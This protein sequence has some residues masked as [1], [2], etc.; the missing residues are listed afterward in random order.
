M[1]GKRKRFAFPVLGLLLLSACTILQ[2]YESQLPPLDSGSADFSNYVAL[3]AAI[4]AGYHSGALY[5]SAQYYSFP[6]ILSRSMRTEGFRQPRIN[7]PGWSSPMPGEGHL[8]IRFDDA[9]VPTME[10]LPWPEGWETNTDLWPGPLDLLDPL[11]HQNLSI[12]LATVQ[13]LLNTR[14]PFDA[15]GQLNP[16]YNFILRNGIEECGWFPQILSAWEQAVLLNPTFLTLSAG[17]S[18]VLTP[19]LFGTGVPLASGPEFESS[20]SQLLDSLESHLPDCDLLLL[21]VPSVLDFAFFRSVPPR[22]IGHDLEELTLPGGGG[23]P[24]HGE[25]GVLLEEDLVLLEA[26]FDVLDG[27]GLPRDEMIQYFM[28]TEA[29]EEASAAAM[30]DS[31]YPRNGELLSENLVLRESEWTQLADRVIDYNQSIAALAEARGHC[32]VDFY[33]LFQRVLD[34]SASFNGHEMSAEFL[35]NFFSL[36]GIHPTR[37]GNALIVDEITSVINE[38]FHS[39]LQVPLLEDLP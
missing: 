5:E 16:Y 34:G 18:E 15:Q 22:A 20:Y 33:S 13:D 39:N 2:P 3:G 14:G 23:I 8:V 30:L 9:G 4:S 26:L 10:P 25:E 21:N 17:I 12:P 19:A 24:L 29:L 1:T 36:D 6:A 28:D 37:F 31:L 32:H 11:P 27:V 35:G 7:S 38:R